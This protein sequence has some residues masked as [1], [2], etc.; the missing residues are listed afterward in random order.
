MR[1]QYENCCHSISLL[2]TIQHCNH[3]LAH[4]CPH[5]GFSRSPWLPGPPAIFV[6]EVLLRPS[7]AH[8]FTCTIAELSSCGRVWSWTEEGCGPWSRGKLTAAFVLPGLSRWFPSFQIPYCSTL[9]LLPV[10]PPDLNPNSTP[11]L[12]VATLLILPPTTLVPVSL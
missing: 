10:M 4:I 12:S 6:N 1:G 9:V 3:C 5:T 2:T 11:S 7:H 8:L